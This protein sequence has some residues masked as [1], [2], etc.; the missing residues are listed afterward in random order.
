MYAWVSSGSIRKYDRAL[1]QIRKENITRRALNQPEVEATEEVV[2]ALYVKWGGL[3]LGEPE[4]VLGVPEGEEAEV[5]ARVEELQP[6]RAPVKKA[7]K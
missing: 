6:E 1:E 2:K 4:S 7:K 5:L 3:L